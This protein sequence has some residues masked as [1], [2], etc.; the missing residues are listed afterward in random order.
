[1][2]HVL[3]HRKVVVVFQRNDDGSG[4]G[5]GSFTFSL[6]GNEPVE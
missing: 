1:V 6:G 3:N 4:G 5:G 2:F